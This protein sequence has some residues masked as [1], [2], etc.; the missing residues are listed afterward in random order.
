MVAPDRDAALRR[1]A[2]LPERGVHICCARNCRAAAR[3]KF[4]GAGAEAGFAA[5]RPGHFEQ[6]GAARDVKESDAR[7]STNE[8][9]ITASRIRGE[10]SNYR[11]TK[12]RRRLSRARVGQTPLRN[13]HRLLGPIRPSPWAFWPSPCPPRPFGAAFP[14]GMIGEGFGR[15][16]SRASIAGQRARDPARKRRKRWN[17]RSGREP[18]FRRRQLLGA[19][20]AWERSPIGT[21][22]FCDFLDGCTLGVAVSAQRF[23]DSLAASGARIS[24]YWSS[25][26]CEGASRSTMLATMS[27]V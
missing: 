6:R 22:D 5:D 15:P 13:E 23:V 26:C 9:E 12:C 11:S 14:S 4:F 1:K 18:A 25:A 17:R 2:P 10:P 24:A 27:V 20:D 16:L 19:G 8:P 7:S 3:G 21:Q